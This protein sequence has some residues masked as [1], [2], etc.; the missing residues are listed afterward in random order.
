MATAKKNKSATVAR[1]QSMIQGLQKHNANAEFTLQSKTF[2][3]GAL[4]T[5]FQGLVDAITKVNAAEAATTVAVAAAGEQQAQTE[6]VYTS[7]KQN[8]QGTHGPDAQ[9]LG[10]YGLAPR[11]TPAPLTAAEKAA[12]AVKR[13]ATRKARGTKGTK[14]RAAI[15]G[16]V[17][18]VIVTPITATPATTPTQ[19]AAAS[20]AT[21]AKS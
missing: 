20:P 5:L 10:D 8:L 7:L 6:H 13:D 18:G 15:K 16:D 4:V 2:T 14:Q 9:T 11:K 19:P 1:M 17:T 21:T 3:T 12:A